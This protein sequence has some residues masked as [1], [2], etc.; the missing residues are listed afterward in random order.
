MGAVD[1]RE[2]SDFLHRSEWLDQPLPLSPLGVFVGVVGV[3]VLVFLVFAV[4]FVAL[5]E[6]S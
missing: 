2:R 3:G 6:G 5:E 4:G 1:D